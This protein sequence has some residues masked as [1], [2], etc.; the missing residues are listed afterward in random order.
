MRMMRPRAPRIGAVGL[1]ACLAAPATAQRQAPPPP[2]PP[3]GIDVDVGVG[4]E[5]ANID[6][7]VV[8]SNLPQL[9]P[10]LRVAISPGG[11]K[12]KVILGFYGHAE[13]TSPRDATRFGLAA[14]SL[15][16][17]NLV[18]AI[19]SLT[20]LQAFGKRGDV[21]VDVSAAY[22]L[23]PNVDGV[24]KLNNMGIFKVGLGTPG[25]PIPLR[26]G[27]VYETGG[28]EGV[29]GEATVGGDFAVSPVTKVVLR[30]DAGWAFR[31]EV[32]G[33]TSPRIAA[34]ARD[35][36]THLDLTG[37]LDLTVAGAGVRPLVTVTYAKDTTAAAPPPGAPDEYI[38]L[39]RFGVSLSFRKKLPSAPPPASAAPARGARPAGPPRN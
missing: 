17:P 34:L 21:A 12:S 4:F 3:L 27:G 25:S 26:V 7:G 37:G 24:T 10:Q 15:K 2:K 22:R 29:S 30:A 19:P 28:I 20:F 11:S 36:F 9:A 16:R 5:T 18:E 31:Q 14:D 23:F 6:R 13:L 35:G 8:L 38:W 32:L 33:G 39:A 1:L